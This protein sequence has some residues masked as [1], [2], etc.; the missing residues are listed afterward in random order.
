MSDRETQKVQNPK[1]SIII[2]TFNTNIVLGQCLD[3]LRK[4]SADK[5]WFEVIVINDGGRKGVSDDVRPMEEHLSIRYMYQDHKGPAAARNLGIEAARGD[6]ILLLDDDSLPATD[7]M[8]ATIAAWERYPGYDGIGGYVIKDDADSI[9]CRVNADFFNWYLDQ[10]SS[11]DDCLFL[12]T[13]NA[14][15]RKSMLER[16]GRFDERFTR[17]SGED[18]DLN[19]KILKNGGKLK[20]DDSILVYHDRDLTFLSFVKKNFNYGKAAYHIYTRYPEQ[21]YLS[22]TSYVNFYASIMRKYSGFKE[23]FMAFFL[24]TLSQAATATGYYTALLTKKAPD[25]KVPQG[26]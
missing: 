5:D 7:W 6:I 10:N 18:R 13:C 26:S 19:I 20:L 25:T 11:A 4:Q 9:Y 21:K 12:V 1:F 22:S 3:A 24:I 17:A 14:G 23:K 16:I 2:P 8:A 15:Y